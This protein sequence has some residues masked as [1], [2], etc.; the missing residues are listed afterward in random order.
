LVSIKQIEKFFLGATLFCIPFGLGAIFNHVV[1]ADLILITDVFMAGLY[2]VWFYRTNL[3]STQRLGFGALGLA[4]VALIIWS[5]FSM[6][7][8]IALQATGLGIYFMIK[9]L[10]LYFYLINNIRTKADIVFVANMLIW[11]LLVQGLIGTLQWLAKGSI[12]LGFL[13][14]R[15]MLLQKVQSRVRGTIGYPNR[16][17]AIL[18]L[19]LPLA[20]SMAIFAKRSLYRWL[21]IVASGFGLFGLFLSLSRASWAGFLI[22]MV[23][24]V[25]LLFRR[26]L[27]KPKFVAAFFMLIVTMIIIVG[28]NWD[29]IERRFETGADGRYRAR[30]VDIS[31]DIIEAYPIFGVGLNNY[32]WHSYS[33]FNFWHPVHNEF[34]RFAAETGI[35]GSIMFTLLLIVFLREAYKGLLIRDTFINAVAIG[36]FCGLIAFIVAINIGP[37][38]QHYRIKLIFWALG[39]ITFA[40]RRVKM[41]ERKTEKNRAKRQQRNEVMAPAMDSISEMPTHLLPGDQSRRP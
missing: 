23:F 3:F 9:S 29:R 33:R 16:Y 36:I 37:E 41:L 17:G 26:G 40:L 39:G 35:P 24:F 13:G 15:Q 12:G 27:L 30:M 8:A 10:L 6:T 21:L 34:L 38:Y 19:L 7:S 22:G 20:F 25:I 1:S 14:E 28:L 31:M 5:V 32:Q 4:G 2:C 11:A 18:I